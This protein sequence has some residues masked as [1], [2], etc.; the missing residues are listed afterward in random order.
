MGKPKPKTESAS[1]PPYSSPEVEEQAEE[2]IGN[3]GKPPQSEM[4]HQTY[5]V[6]TDLHRRIKM[7]SV[8]TRTRIQD[9]LSEAMGDLLTKYNNREAN[10]SV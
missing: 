8:E 4:S 3:P 1:I 10:T 9:L 2:Q 7:L 6:P 5:L